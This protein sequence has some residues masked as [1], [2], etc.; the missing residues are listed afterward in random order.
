MKNPIVFFTC[1]LLSIF[2]S[3]SSMSCNAIEGNV[4]QTPIDMTVTEP[5][6]DETE[7]VRE[8]SKTVSVKKQDSV[9]VCNSRS[10][11]AYHSAYCSGLKRC[12]ASVSKIPKT[13]AEAQGKKA[14][15]YCYN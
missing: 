10:A 5:L 12:K 11:Y 6:S 1:V 8:R 9:F 3:I 4:E 13:D 2:P 14:C 7:P 15:G